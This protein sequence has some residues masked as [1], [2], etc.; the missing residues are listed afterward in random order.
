MKLFVGSHRKSFSCGSSIWWKY[1]I[2]RNGERALDRAW[3][4]EISMQDVADALAS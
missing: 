4:G 2:Y 3:I 1:Q